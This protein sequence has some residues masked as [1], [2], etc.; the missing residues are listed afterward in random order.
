MYGWNDQRPILAKL[1]FVGQVEEILDLNYGVFNTIIL[2]CNWVKA[3]YIRRS[4]TIKQNEYG[5]KLVN[6]S[7]FIPISNSHLFSPYM[8]NKCF[9]LITQ[10]NGGGK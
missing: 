9:F 5:F 8:L 3:N 1:E 4:A 6:F 7:S 10:K 2:S